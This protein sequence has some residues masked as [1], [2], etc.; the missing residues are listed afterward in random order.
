[1]GQMFWI[2]LFNTLESN[3]LQGLVAFT[4]Y[5]LHVVLNAF[6]KGIDV[7]GEDV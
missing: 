4:P 3:D 5:T 2:L 6:R 7:F 1:M